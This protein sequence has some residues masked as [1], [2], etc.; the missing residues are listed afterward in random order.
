MS[1]IL[2]LYNRAELTLWCLRSVIAAAQI[3]AEVLLVDNNSKDYTTELLERTEGARIIRNNENKGFLLAVNQAAQAARGEYLLLLNNDAKLLPG[4]LTATVRLMEEEPNVGVVGGKILALDGRVQECGSIIWQDGSCQGYGRGESAVVPEFTFRRDVDYCS[5]AFLLTS[6][7]LFRELNG[8][9]E[10][11]APAYYEET[12]YCMRV[13]KQGLRVVC[14]PRAC[15]AHYEFASSDN[16]EEAIALQRTNQRTFAKKH[17]DRLQSHYVAKRGNTLK[18]R[19]AA[20]PNTH[21]LYIDDR[22]PHTA[23]GSGFPRAN[24][25]VRTLVGL[26]Y[27]LTVY[28]LNFPNEDKL[29]ARLT[30]IFHARRRSCWTTDAVG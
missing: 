28:P 3:P 22:V 16:R 10:I 8:F 30:W 4:T 27:S 19:F 18:A 20:G 21:V 1:I 9:D 6:T 24:F 12:D 7:N 13:R 25:T 2:V 26:G 5:G 23:L 11:Y 14:D 29:G 15:V 17:G